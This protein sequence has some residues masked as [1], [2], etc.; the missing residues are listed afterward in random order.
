M[1][2]S[3]RD[4]KSLDSGNSLV[5]LAC[6][7]FYPV[8][9]LFR[10]PENSELIY[11]VVAIAV[12][13]L[14]Y[15]MSARDRGL[16]LLASAAFTLFLAVVL[17]PVEANWTV[18]VI[19]A[20]T[21]FGR[22]DSHVWAVRGI[23]GACL[24]AGVTGIL[25]GQPWFWWFPGL[26]LSAL[27]GLSTIRSLD[28]Q[29]ENKYLIVRREAERLESM[30][31]E[32][33]RISRDLHDLLGRS[34]TS[35]AVKTDLAARLINHDAVAAK[36]EINEVA[37]LARESLTEVRR[38]VSG[39]GTVSLAREIISAEKILG[40]A[41]ILVEVCGPPPPLT[42]PTDNALAMTLREAVTNVLKHSG[43]SK[44]TIRIV[45]GDAELDLYVEDNGQGGH[46]VEGFGLMGI[47]NRLRELGGTSELVPMA[48][49]MRFHAM[50]P[51]TKL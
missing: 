33:E 34:L 38:Y 11:S 3:I 10:A 42:K 16:K 51:R 44:C 39:E 17:A 28:L 30:L 6:L 46:P 43:A 25:T 40:S 14:I 50:V 49:G 8:P 37:A 1:K 31:E 27:I 22:L 47:R 36:D 15:F 26:A 35:I 29:R 13:L 41:G 19:F 2:I 7:I 18:F 9:W 45:E 23:I 4:Q 21:M 5:W 20:A 32:R 24:I 48:Q 12:F